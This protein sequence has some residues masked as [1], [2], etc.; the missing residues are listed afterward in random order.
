VIAITCSHNIEDYI[1]I[2][3][4]YCTNINKLVNILSSKRERE[5]E[6]ETMNLTSGSTIA[7]RI[8]LS[9]NIIQESGSFIKRPREIRLILHQ[10]VA[11]SFLQREKASC[12]VSQ[13]T[14]ERGREG[15]REGDKDKIHFEEENLERKRKYFT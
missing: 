14:R 4:I 5:R 6:I 1:I 3:K 8:K 13:E 12:N 11:V 9:L 2:N 10:N 7:E 15:E